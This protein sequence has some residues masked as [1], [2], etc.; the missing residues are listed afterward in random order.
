MKRERFL[1]QLQLQLPSHQSVLLV[2]ETRSE[3]VHAL[4]QL[5]ASAL[6]APVREAEESD[7]A[8]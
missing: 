8:R 4:A 7:E 1:I 5:L 3:I 6:A 2:S